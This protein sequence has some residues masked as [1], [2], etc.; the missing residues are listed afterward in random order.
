MLCLF[1]ASHTALTGQPC[2]TANS[3]K[4]ESGLAAFKEYKKMIKNAAP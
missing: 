3:R 1:S 4:Y 2:G